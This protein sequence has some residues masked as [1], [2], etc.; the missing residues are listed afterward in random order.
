MLSKARDPYPNDFQGVAPKPSIDVVEIQA[1][2]TPVPMLSL[3]LK[4]EEYSSREHP[5]SSASFM[6]GVR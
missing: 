2:A 1:G 5:W 6:Y 4:G 3:S